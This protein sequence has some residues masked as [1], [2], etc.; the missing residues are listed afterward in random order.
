MIQKYLLATELIPEIEAD[1]AAHITSPFSP[2]HVTHTHLCSLYATS[3]TH[4]PMLII[5]HVTHTHLCS[6]YSTSHTHSPMLVI[7]HGPQ[8]D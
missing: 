3:H 4:S 7:L 1:Q 5:L 2:K 8:G 6:L